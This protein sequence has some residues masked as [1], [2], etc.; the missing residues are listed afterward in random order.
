MN[1]HGKM[2]TRAEYNKGII[3]S[4]YLGKNMNKIFEELIT[5]YYYA[6]AK[7]IGLKQL[8]NYY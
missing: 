5:D 8:R 1:R 7:S 2:S 4:L 6:K 3:E